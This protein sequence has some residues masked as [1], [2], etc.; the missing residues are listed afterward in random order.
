MPTAEAIEVR[1]DTLPWQDRDAEEFEPND[2]EYH[3][4]NERD[5]TEQYAGEY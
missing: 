3:T 4:G 5:Q 2:H 1:T